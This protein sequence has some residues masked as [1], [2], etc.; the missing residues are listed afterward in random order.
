MAIYIIDIKEFHKD[1]PEFEGSLTFPDSNSKHPVKYSEIKGGAIINGSLVTLTG[2]EMPFG[3]LRYFFICP[4]CRDRKQILVLSHSGLACRGCMGIAPPSL[5]RSKNDCN[6]YW[7]L[8]E[9][10]GQSLDPSFS[11][12]PALGNISFP[13]KPKGMHWAT[14]SAKYKKYMKYREQGDKAWLGAASGGR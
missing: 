10:V 2:V 7:D 8:A 6:Y 5:N 12:Y 13:D 1:G 4:T 14:Y 11:V 9:K 3:G